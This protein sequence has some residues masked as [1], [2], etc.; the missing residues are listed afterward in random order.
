MSKPCQSRCP[1]ACN[2]QELSGRNL[3]PDG[4]QPELQADIYSM[5]ASSSVQPSV[6]VS[7]IE[8]ASCRKTPHTFPHQKLNRGTPLATIQVGG[9]A[10][11]AA[12]VVKSEGP[13][14]QPGKR[15][16][17]EDGEAG[18]RERSSGSPSA[19]PASSLR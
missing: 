9:G 2:F 5:P 10:A 15:K 13:R 3:R 1:H 7:K 6:R 17:R 19:G 16:K 8:C 18:F 14:R 12:A 11:A 4:E